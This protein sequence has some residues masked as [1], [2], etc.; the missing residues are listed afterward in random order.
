[1]IERVIEQRRRDLG[2]GM[3]VGRVLPFAKRRMVGPYIFFDHIGPLDLPPGVDRSVDVRP[4]PHIG[5]STVS[6]LFA[7]EIMHRD[8][9]GYAQAVR[10]W[11]VNWMT[12]G[13]G[14]TQSEGLE[15]ARAHGDHVHGIQAWSRCRPNMK[16]WPPAFHTR[17]AATCRSG[18]QSIG[19]RIRAEHLP[20]PTAENPHPAPFLTA[21]TCP[22]CPAD[23]RHRACAGLLHQPTPT[24][25]HRT[26]NMPTGLLPTP[27]KHLLLAGSLALA[28]IV[29]LGNHVGMD[30]TGVPTFTGDPR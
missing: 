29:A 4:H 5:L 22:A 1:M 30:A 7:G 8:S 18:T 10:P 27:R 26:P 23:G 2:G 14:I 24:D 20:L 12:A 11:E 19:Q 6:Y 25:T 15:H 13:R 21:E 28:W 17:P 3:E 16:S 9:L